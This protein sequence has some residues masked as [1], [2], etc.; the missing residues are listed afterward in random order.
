MKTSTFGTMLATRKGRREER[1]RVHT[2]K[3]VDPSISIQCRK[4]FCVGRSSCSTSMSFSHMTFVVG[5]LCLF[6][7]SFLFFLAGQIWAR[8]P[9]V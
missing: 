7:M 9:G 8:I 5:K 1:S 3:K 2:R 4:P 6:S